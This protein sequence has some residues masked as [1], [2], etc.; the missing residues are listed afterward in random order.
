MVGLLHEDEAK[1]LVRGYLES[2]EWW[3]FLDPENLGHI[4]DIEE[5]FYSGEAN[6][7]FHLVMCPRME[8]PQGVVGLCFGR[9]S[10][11]PKEILE[12]WLREQGMPDEDTMGDKQ[13]CLVFSDKE[14]WLI[15]P[16]IIGGWAGL[17]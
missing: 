1:T 4:I 13:D 15:L 16:S 10:R 7:D 17:L 9:K 14:H 12:A 5:K 2:R 6:A 3:L 8:G 11:L